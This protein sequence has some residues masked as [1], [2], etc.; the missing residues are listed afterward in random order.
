MSAA[1]SPPEDS[2]KLERER[3]KRELRAR[4]KAEHSAP[5]LTITSQPEIV[6]RDAAYWT[7]PPELRLKYMKAAEEAREK[8]VGHRKT[9]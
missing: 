6:I 5:T 1:D 9:I 7:H 3:K 8:W 4:L 2:F